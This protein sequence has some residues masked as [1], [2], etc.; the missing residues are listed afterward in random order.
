MWLDDRLVHLV[1]ADAHRAGV[2]DARERDD[3]D[4]GG[5]PADVD[6]HVAGRLGDGQA[7]AD[8][9]GDGL[10]D[11]VDLARTGDLRRLLDRA[12]LD[13]GDAERHADDDARLDERR[14]LVR[15][16]G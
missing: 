8:G 7:G 15:T 11:Q 3:R 2:H 16:G 9:R 10:L 6:D 1:A 4:L 14:A 5:A 13:L 12:L